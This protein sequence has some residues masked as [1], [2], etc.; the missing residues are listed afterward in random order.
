MKLGTQYGLLRFLGGMILLCL[1]INI[2]QP[3][4]KTTAQSPSPQE[5][6]YVE[7]LHIDTNKPIDYIA[8]NPE[9]DLIASAGDIDEIYHRINIWNTTNGELVYS[10]DSLV[11]AN[12]VVEL[13]WN[14][15][16]D[17]LASALEWNLVEIWQIGEPE[18]TVFEQ[19]GLIKAIAWSDNDLLAVA[20]GGDDE[21][22]A[23]WDVSTGEIIQRLQIEY[24]TAASIYSNLSVAKWSPD[25]SSIATLSPEK[26]D[27]VRIWLWG[28]VTYEGTPVYEAYVRDS[29]FALP[30]LEWSPDGNLLTSASCTVNNLD[31]VVWILNVSTA[32]LTYLEDHHIHFID[33]IVWKPDGS[34]LAVSSRRNGVI[35]FL[36]PETG[37]LMGQ[38]EPDGE[39]VSDIVWSPDGQKLVSATKDGVIQIWEI[40]YQED[41]VD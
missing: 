29:H 25:G 6:Q 3:L 10:F 38:I 32:E 19:S 20:G 4:W 31:C 40:E 17:L 24:A 7:V 2:H 21:H 18:P 28:A 13:S 9:N 34:M 22:I 30:I 37:D 35:N 5:F 16:G 41:D 8:W 39:V 12:S 26:L 23:I 1:V 33:A 11:R 14:F 27:L 36:N 15:T